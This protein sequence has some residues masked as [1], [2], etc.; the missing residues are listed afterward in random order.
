MRKFELVE[1]SFKSWALLSGAPGGVGGAITSALG[2]EGWK[3]L[4]SVKL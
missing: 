2:L 1:G 3:L 4:N